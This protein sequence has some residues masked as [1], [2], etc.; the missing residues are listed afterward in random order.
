MRKRKAP[1]S[2]R[3]TFLVHNDKEIPPHSTSEGTEGTQIT[4]SAVYTDLLEVGLYCSEAES[5]NRDV[6]I[7]LG[8]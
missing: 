1:F 8:G 3:F 4:C 6:Y 5:V 2:L 7:L